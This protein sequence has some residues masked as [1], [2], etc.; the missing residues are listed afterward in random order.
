MLNRDQDDIVISGMSVNTPI[1]DTL[2]SFVDALY[3]GRSA[4]SRWHSIDTKSCYSKVGA[5]LGGYDTESR[6]EQLRAVLPNE[7]WRRLA[8]L[9]GSLPWSTKLTTLLATDAFIDAELIARVRDSSRIG[10]IVSGHNI[11]VN[12]NFNNRTQFD[13]RPD[14]ID[15]LYGLQTLDTDHATAVTQVL[16]LKGPAYLVGGA[17]ASGNLAI[18]SAID[19]LR[20]HQMDAVIVV[21]PVLEW[22]PLLL[23][24]MALLGAITF[25]NFHDE[26][27][28]ASR[29]YDVARE[30]FVPAHGGAAL[31]LEAR[32]VAES[33]GVKPYASILGC[34]ATSSASHLPTPLAETQ[35][36]AMQRTLAVSGV[37][38]G[39]IAY[40]NAHATSTPQGDLAELDAIKGAFGHHAENIAIN[41]PKSLLGHT[42]WSAPIVETVAAVLQMNRGKVH[43]SANIDEL[44]GKVDLDVTANGTR[45]LEIPYM[46]KNSFGFGGINCVSVLQ[47]GNR[48]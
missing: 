11:G 33:R 27:S 18:R 36:I 43:R 41:A 30:G 22:S 7:I 42:C 12:Y 14:H 37:D 5:D 8:K 21:G 17:C 45:D 31:V 38:P 20:H 48:L 15:P 2:N 26:P 24:G 19:E 9:H 4:I 23:H 6:I 3:D 44:D 10:V 13:A 28:K 32:S 39:D 1:G 47:N 16:G 25:K 29:P 34:E 35:S 40:V 46:V